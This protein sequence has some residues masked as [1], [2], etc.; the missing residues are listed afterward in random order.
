M[1]HSKDRLSPAPKP[2][3]VVV[4][5]VD[6]ALLPEED[7]F[8]AFAAAASAAT[9]AAATFLAASCSANEVSDA[10]C[11]RRAATCREGTISP[12]V[13]RPEDLA[14]RLSAHSHW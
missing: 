5:E 8:A 6:A 14:N 9:A 12:S 11:N 2:L 1:D 4:E 3:D 13:K 7:S 10:S